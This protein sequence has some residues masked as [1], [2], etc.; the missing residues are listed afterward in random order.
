MTSG[1][2][3]IPG[4]PQELVERAQNDTDY[5]LR[6]L[7]RESR[8]GALREAGLDLSGDERIQLDRRLDEI[9]NLSFQ[10]ALEQLGRFGFQRFV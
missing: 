6:L 8:E 2:G 1:D 3:Q 5:A 4:I 7:N 10:D 9:A